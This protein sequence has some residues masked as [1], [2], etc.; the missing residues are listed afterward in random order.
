MDVTNHRPR[1]LHAEFR[2]YRERIPGCYCFVA[3]K[4]QE[5]ICQGVVPDVAPAFLTRSLRVRVLVS[6]EGY[7]SD[8]VEHD[9]STLQIRRDGHSR[10]EL[11]LA[12]HLSDMV[13]LLPQLSVVFSRPPK[14]RKPHLS[15]DCRR[16]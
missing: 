14:P 7:H 11:I 10:Q 4:G 3:I 9:R 8:I 5:D 15:I 16:M 1:R 6:Y 2:I 12:A 13:Y